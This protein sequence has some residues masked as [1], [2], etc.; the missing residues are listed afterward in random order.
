MLATD[1]ATWVLAKLG[2]IVSPSVRRGM[3]SRPESGEGL[4]LETMSLST[5]PA[6]NEV[7]QVLGNSGRAEG[8]FGRVVQIPEL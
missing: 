8:I 7:G 5:H 3:V 1:W 4:V 2:V 6:Q